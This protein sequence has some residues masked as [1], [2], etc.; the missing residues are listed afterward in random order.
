MHVFS[1]KIMLLHHTAPDCKA[2]LDDL[3]T[4]LAD[5]QVVKDTF[6][7]YIW[8]REQHYP[9][10]LLL[11]QLGVAIPHTDAQYVN[12]DQIGIMTLTEP[13]MFASMA[14]PNETVPVRIIFMLALHKSEAQ[15]LLLQQLMTFFQEDQL[16][17][18]LAQ[19]TDKDDVLR[20][21]AQAQLIEI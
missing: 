12:K 15:P 19:A 20:L 17:A 8:E 7:T 6:A 10:G 18:Q 21:L 9:T 13:V 1:E 16:L 14:D 11:N 5:Q 2:A 4:A 3:A